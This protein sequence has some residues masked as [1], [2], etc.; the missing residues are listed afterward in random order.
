MCVCIFVF[1]RVRMCL[2]YVSCVWGSTS[3]VFPSC[4]VPCLFFFLSALLSKI[5]PVGGD[6]GLNFITHTHAHTHT[7]PF[8]QPLREKGGKH[9]V[10]T[11]YTYTHTHTCTHTHTESLVYLCVAIFGPP[12]LLATFAASFL[13]TCV[14]VCV[15]VC[16]C[17]YI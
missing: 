1:V 10:K 11:R 5:E 4:F 13:M 15:C 14:C 16:L 12:L 8:T 9:F 6:I 7:D 3:F 17:E 2:V